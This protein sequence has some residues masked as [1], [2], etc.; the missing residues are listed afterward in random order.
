MGVKRTIVFVCGECD[1]P[2]ECLLIL[3]GDTL[4]TPPCYCPF[5]KGRCSWRLCDGKSS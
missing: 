2:E 5:T 1:K 3:Y 4:S